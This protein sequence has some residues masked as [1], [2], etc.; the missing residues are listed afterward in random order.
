VC[1]FHRANT[2]HIEHIPEIGMR[3]MGITHYTCTVFTYP[4]IFFSLEFFYLPFSVSNQ[5]W[6]SWIR[7]WICHYLHG[8]GSGSGSRSVSFH[9]QA[10]N[11]RITLISIVFLLLN[12]LLSLKIDVNYL[13]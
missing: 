8:S 13:Q 9:Q 7:I 1:Y 12:D 5:V 2:V 6:A 4:Y 3:P 10:K 11:F